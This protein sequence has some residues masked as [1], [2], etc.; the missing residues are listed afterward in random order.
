MDY[1]ARRDV[2][3]LFGGFEWDEFVALSDTWEWNGTWTRRQTDVHPP[4]VIAPAMA[5][6]HERGVM[7]LFGGILGGYD[8]VLTNQTWEWDGQ[9]WT[10]RLPAVVPPPRHYHALVYDAARKKI[11]LHG[12]SV[13]NSAGQT[14]ALTDT[15]EWD[16]TNWTEV[17]TDD[18]PPGR[19]GAFIAY[20]A[21]RGEVV[22]F[23]GVDNVFDDNYYNDTWTYDGINWTLKEPAQRPDARY[24]GRM[25]WDPLGERVLLFGGRSSVRYADT[26]AW[27]GDDWSP[28]TTT[29]A[30]SERLDFGTAAGAR[31]L[32]LAAT[33][34]APATP[35]R[36]AATHGR[37]SPLRSPWTARSTRWLPIHC[38][39][40]SSFWVGLG[41]LTSLAP[42]FIAM[43]SGQDSIRPTRHRSARVQ[44][45]PTTVPAARWSSL[46]A[47]GYKIPGPGTGRTGRLSIQ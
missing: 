46:V 14:P 41:T 12:G 24:I 38:A 16:G 5:Y 11:V 45:L 21:K 40:K 18:V 44:P 28:V 30:P 23:G 42:G 32:S 39:E 7:V 37:M 17:I 8:G 3:V 20:D 1:D 35:G 15:W 43:A 19:E 2:V 6:D 33:T 10:Q 9:A 34:A 26:W 27:N 47:V 31:P 36:C 25:V 22:L 13:Y 29:A 4:A